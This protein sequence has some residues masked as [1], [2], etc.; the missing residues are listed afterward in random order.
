MIIRIVKLEFKDDAIDTFK[1]IFEKSKSSILAFDG[2]D[3]VS[4]LQSEDNPNLFF[5]YSRWVS[6]E[7]LN[8]YRTSDFFGKVWPNTKHLLAN[9]PEAWSTIQLSST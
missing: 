5:T 2:C 4:L 6:S 9:K 3:H 8:K 1:S 7:H